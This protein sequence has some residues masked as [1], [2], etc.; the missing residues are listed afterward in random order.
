[1]KNFT[2][3]LL[4]FSI[5]YTNIKAQEMQSSFDTIQVSSS[6]IPLTIAET[7]RNITVLESVD[8]QQMSFT[9]ID[10]L[11]Q[12]IPGIEVQSRNAF[13]A[14]GDI[15]MR[16]ATFTQVLILIDGLKLNDPLTAHFNSNIPVTPAEIY[17][18]EVLRGAAA[19]MYGADAVGGVIH[20]QTKAFAKNL[21]DETE[22]SG[23]LNYGE[24]ALINARQG[25]AIKK[26]KLYVGGGFSMNQSDGETI[27]ERVIPLSVNASGDTT[28]GYSL[29]AFDNFFDLK[30]IGLGFSYDFGKGFVLRGRTA[31]D[32]RDFSAR[33]F[34]T[35]ST[36]DKSVETT[37][38][39]WNQIQLSKTGNKSTTDLNIGYKNNTDLFIFSP[40]FPST[41]SHT[42]EYF[43]SQINHLQII[44]EQLSLKFGV[45]VDQRK[46]E[47]N[48]RGN[49]KDW[50]AGVYAMG[51]YRP[52]AQL[53]LTG[54]IRL[55]YDENY[56]LEFSP[57]LNVSYVLPSIVLRASVG[58]SIRAA[59]YTERFVSF[60]IE[61]LT[62]GRSL[63]NPDL[64]AENSWSEEIGIDY[65]I[66]SNFQIK[67][68]GFL[69]QSSNLIDYIQ[70]NES[71]IPNN[72][73]LRD[74]ANYFFASNITDV[75]TKGFEVE[76]W[77]K[78]Q[79][80]E[81]T[82]I[83]VSVGYTYLNTSNEEEVIS[84]YISSHA[85][86]LFTTNAIFLAGRFELG[87][88]GLYKTRN[89]RAAA[90][91]DANLENSYTVW[92]GRVGFQLLEN[93]G[94]N[95]QIHNILDKEYQDILGAPMPGRWMMGGL[96]FQF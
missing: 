6:R 40:D 14:Q 76:A 96:K 28:Q 53:N 50:H 64:V 70:T 45:Q 39:W 94:L 52:T 36:F 16:G 66:N 43:N 51:V 11:L 55:D 21:S 35:T 47:S 90:A 37:R 30:T 18:I 91:I 68:T 79:I 73:K 42:S 60:D 80:N 38:H 22:I 23:T 15:T 19:A 67:A 56:D 27:S 57:Q 20:I 95:F 69:R 48:D 9:S 61:N 4:F 63:G 85:G 3:V 81:R 71:N 33:Y 74:G 34:Y 87:I 72:T 75:T 29:E 86:D 12:F 10:D 88:N 58:K 7:G 17:R 46:I 5:F 84:V 82:R 77:Y 65:N 92:N 24:H 1:M 13:G 26:D 59:D 78:N 93:F 83:L 89:A 25:F 32:Y 49:H 54:S 44:N 62:P 31:Y 41:N 8:I 2:L